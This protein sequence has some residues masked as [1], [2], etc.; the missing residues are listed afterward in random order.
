VR[1]CRS[2]L[3]FQAISASRRMASVRSGCRPACWPK[4][5]LL[6]IHRRLSHIGERNLNAIGGKVAIVLV[7]NNVSHAGADLA[8]RIAV[9]LRHPAPSDKRGGTGQGQ[10]RAARNRSGRFR[11]RAA[12]AAVRGWPCA[13]TAAGRGDPRHRSP[14]CRRRRTRTRP[15]HIEDEGG[16]AVTQR[17]AAAMAGAVSQ[18]AGLQWGRTLDEALQHA[19][20]AAGEWAQA[21]SLPRPRLLEALRDDS[22]VKAAFAD[23]DGGSR[24]SRSS[25]ANQISRITAGTLAAVG[26]GAATCMRC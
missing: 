5:L 24:S 1:F 3:R 19:M 2:F 26:E 9:S 20:E 16:V 17:M 12:P 15:R 11:P 25:V 18:S 22:C 21:V 8:G 13:S 23:G 7:D 14:G 10:S 4:R 6:A